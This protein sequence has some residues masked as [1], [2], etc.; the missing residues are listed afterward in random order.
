MRVQT[1]HPDDIPPWLTLAAEVEP[2]FGPMVSDPA[3]HAALRKNIDRG[4]AFCVRVDDGP[5]G[6]PLMGAILFSPYPPKYT[7]GWLAVAGQ[8]RQRGVGRLLVERA[9]TLVRPPAEVTL[10]TFAEGIPDGLPAR[11]FYA[12]LG[13]L[14]GEPGPINAAG[15]AT[16]VFRRVFVHVPTVRAVIQD[17][18]RYLLVQHEPASTPGDGVWALPGGRVTADDPD[19][20]ATLRREMREEFQ[21]DI[22]IVRLIGTYTLRERQHHVFHVRPRSTDLTPEPS[23]IVAVGWFTLDE[24]RACYA[25][26]K[27]FAP[28]MLDAIIASRDH[29]PEP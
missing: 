19:Y 3:F 10:V 20:E 1:A 4:T 28:F 17:G 25:A 12:R 29:I 8:W 22:D 18:E 23:E 6:A 2:L 26:G 11:R 5:P 13:F 27:L 15:F 14:P 24:V 7:I 16:Q 9:L 21:I